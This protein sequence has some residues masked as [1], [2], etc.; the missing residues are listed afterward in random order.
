MVWRH[1]T[2]TGSASSSATRARI[3]PNRRRRQRRVVR[4]G[5][6]AECPVLAPAAD[7]TAVGAGHGHDCDVPNV[8]YSTFFTR[9][10]EL[11]DQIASGL[12]FRN[13]DFSILGDC[14][15]LEGVSAHSQVLVNS[16]HCF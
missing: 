7:G 4:R 1:V 3:S 6:L 16:D 2:I 11:L 15:T 12:L 9:S 5:P 8:F 10:L 14:D 13:G